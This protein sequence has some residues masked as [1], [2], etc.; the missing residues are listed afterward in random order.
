MHELSIALNIVD[1]AAEEAAARD[2]RV[3][4]VHL[5]LGVFSGVVKEALTAAWTLARENTPLAQAE[6]VVEEIPLVVWC[7][8]CAAER[9]LVWEEGLC[10][11]VCKGATPQV[12]RGR[13]MEV[14]ALEI[15]S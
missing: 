3:T 9:T 15:E 14:F 12:L 8:A 2:G 4:A 10:C 11:P 5:R 6:L 1:V 13:E 7:E